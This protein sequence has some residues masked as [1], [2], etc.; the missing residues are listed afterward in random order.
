MKNF[1]KRSRRAIV[2]FAIFFL[3]IILI[4]RVYFYFRKTPQFS[5]TKSWATLPVE[6]KKK[7]QQ[8]TKIYKKEK[9]RKNTKKF[10]T[11]SAKF[12]PN[13]YT[14]EN[15]QEIGL[16]EK[17]AQTIINFNKFGFFS[18]EDMQKCFVFQN[19][20]LMAEIQDS[21]IFPT[22]K[23]F[24]AKNA[25]TISR[26]IDINKAN[27]EELMQL[28][29]IGNYFADK[30]IEYRNR[31]G[32]FYSTKQLL[33]IYRFDQEKLNSIQPFIQV[34]TATIQKI[35]L[36]TVDIKTLHQHPYVKDWN[37]ANSIVKI[38]TQIDGYQSIDEIKKSV[39]MTD[40][41]YHKLKH[42]LTTE[43]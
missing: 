27:K 5:L 37:L 2:V 13:E 41:V 16:S 38:R 43:E 14:L 30:I 8:R 9:E 22:K 4:P 34:S 28:K 21:L 40:E 1:S 35:N 32:G 6:E 42:Y 7:V 33:E 23:D 29:G 15:W 36:N 25:P 12:D 10:K 39:L 20:Y 24:Q 26:K 11:P 17:Q 18:I 31:L 19:E 3:V